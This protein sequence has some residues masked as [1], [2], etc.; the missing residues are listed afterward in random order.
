MILLSLIGSPIGIVLSDY[1]VKKT[2]RTSGIVFLLM[3]TIVFCAVLIP[4]FAFYR[5]LS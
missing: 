4:P 1:M 2:G 5:V 3:T